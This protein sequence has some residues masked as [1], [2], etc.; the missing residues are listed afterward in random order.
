[1][2]GFARQL[3]RQANRKW[4]EGFTRSVKET[5]R[6]LQNGPN[7]PRDQL[8]LERGLDLV[9]ISAIGQI[10]EAVIES[11]ATNDGTDYPWILE[12]VRIIQPKAG[13]PTGRLHW[14]NSRG[15]WVS[16]KMIDNKHHRWWTKSWGL[17]GGGTLWIQVLR[18]NF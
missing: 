15:D 6:R 1:M 10:K 4:Q 9:S 16:A 12:N 7:I 8:D 3:R 5:H 11:T 17:D 13:N 14:T 2:A 18:E